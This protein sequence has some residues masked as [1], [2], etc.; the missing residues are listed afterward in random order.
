MVPPGTSISIAPAKSSP[1]SAS[2]FAFLSVGLATTISPSAS[3]T[4]EKTH[5]VGTEPMCSNNCPAM[6]VARYAADRS[7]AEV[8]AGRRIVRSP[9]LR[10]QNDREENARADEV[11]TP[12]QERGQPHEG[13]VPHPGQA[14]AYLCAQVPVGEDPLLL[15]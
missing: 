10:Q 14:F 15:K 2:T 13:L 4:P 8:R 6:R 3:V 7:P 5:T 11:E 1:A 9:V 12:T